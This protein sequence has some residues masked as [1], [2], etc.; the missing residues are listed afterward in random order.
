MTGLNSD[1]SK[2]RLISSSFW[3]SLEKGSLEVVSFVVFLVLARLLQPEDYGAV[4]LALVFVTLMSTISTLGVSAAL[5]QIEELDDRHL[6]S[7]FWASL[8]VS[9]L[10]LSISYLCAPLAAS[11]M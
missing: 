10:F 11:G 1:S 9:L 3:S 7:A 8:A 6:S 2:A 5:V 4:A